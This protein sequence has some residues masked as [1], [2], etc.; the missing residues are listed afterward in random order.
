MSSFPLLGFF[1]L[2]LLV[3]HAPLLQRHP[4]FTAAAV[5][6]NSVLATFD[7][8]GLSTLISYCSSFLSVSPSLE[9]IQGPLGFHNLY[10]RTECRYTIPWGLQACPSLCSRL[11]I[12]VP[13]K[14]KFLI[15]QTF[16]SPYTTLFSMSLCQ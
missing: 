13:S 8:I 12:T 15:P 10:T 9:T 4:S 6:D 14:S 2:L 3:V 1:F 7:I 11:S 16:L 5:V